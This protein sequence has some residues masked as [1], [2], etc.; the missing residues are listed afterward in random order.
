[1][2]KFLPGTY[3]SYFDPGPDLRVRLFNPI[4]I[5]GLAAGLLMAVLGAGED[6]YDGD[7]GTFWRNLRGL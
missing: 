7:C 5:G 4:L 6:A 1:M 2:K 3:R